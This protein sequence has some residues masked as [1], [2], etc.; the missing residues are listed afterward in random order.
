VLAAAAPAAATRIE[1]GPYLQ[2]VR[3]D[4]VDVLFETEPPA[5]AEVIVG[6]P[7]DERRFASPAAAR[8][9]VRV[10]GL[11][12]GRH[13]YRVVAGDAA[14]PPASLAPAPA[15]GDFTF[16]VYGDNRDRD[17]DHARVVA[18]M[19]REHAD[20]IL[21]TGD[22]TG[23]A[24]VDALWRRFFSIEARLL[25][26]APMYPALGNHEILH[27]PE[28]AHY[29][30]YFDLP[31]PDGTHER[32]YSF[33]FGGALF[34]ALDGNMSGDRA[35]AAWLRATLASARSDP[36][37]RHLFVFF[38]QPAFSDGSFCGSAHEQGLWVPE[39]EAAGVRAVFTGHDHS[40]QRLERRGVRYFVTGGGGAPLTT[41]SGRCAPYDR[42][43][44]RL[45]RSA[46][47]YLRV[48]IR[49]DQALLDALSPDGE[50]L[51][52][53]SLHEPAPP[54]A[55]PP[56]EVPYLE[57]AAA[58]APAPT[59]SPRAFAISALAVAALGLVVTVLL[60]RRARARLTRR[61]QK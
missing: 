17:E 50:I 27:D 48:R 4:G 6:A 18:A 39:I 29:H 32:W 53:V 45:H 8:H 44:L 41:P 25:S 5:A 38:H 9:E 49:G 42:D 10:T 58:R 30:R 7:P 51:D 12:P 14:S 33:R 56:L 36:S 35:Q 47:H 57:T 24:G 20:L 40:Y 59:L 43:A 16:L 13:P 26:S 31:G 55:K 46:H 2:N 15:A 22:M 52:R 54:E 1:P 3:P 28:A 21:Q 60:A 61:P 11:A 34:I 37:L 23:D 19:E